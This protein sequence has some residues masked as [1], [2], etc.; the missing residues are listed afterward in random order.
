MFLLPK[1]FEQS[2]RATIVPATPSQPGSSHKPDFHKG[3]TGKAHACGTVKARLLAAAKPTIP[4][5]PV[6]AAATHRKNSISSETISDSGSE[7]SNS[8][9]LSEQ[10]PLKIEENIKN[11]TKITK[12]EELKKSL[13]KSKSPLLNARNK[14]PSLNGSK[15]P[16]PTQR[17]M[18]LQSEGERSDIST[19]TN[20]TNTSSAFERTQRY[21][22]FHG[23]SSRVANQ[24]KQKNNAAA[25]PVRPPW[26][27][28]GGVKTAHIPAFS[29]SSAAATPSHN[30]AAT[31]T[32]TFRSSFRRRDNCTWQL[33]WERA[34]ALRDN[35]VSYKTYDEFIKAKV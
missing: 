31:I 20:N 4:P 16:L 35:N 30:A 22:S 23:A 17:R 29:P 32:R 14:T 3:C 7:N 8:W 19:A 26:N 6:P 12:T 10:T 13:Q 9:N 2:L 24:Q 5:K 1:S 27:S 21:R 15:S 25:S 18:R 28:G 34:L 33:L 11:T